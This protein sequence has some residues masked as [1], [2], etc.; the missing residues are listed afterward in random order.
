[1]H[2]LNWALMH[3]THAPLSP[4][5]YDTPVVIQGQGCLMST[6]V[7]LYDYTQRDVLYS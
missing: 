1:M 3:S 2:I 4:V 5:L 7:P 6:P